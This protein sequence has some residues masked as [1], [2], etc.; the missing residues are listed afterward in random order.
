V[1]VFELK[2]EV[3]ESADPAAAAA[4]ASAAAAADATRGMTKE[5]KEAYEK[6]LKERTEALAKNK[7]LN[8]AFNGAMT[9]KEAK[10]Y[11]EAVAQFTK[12]AGLDANQH[13]VWANL[14]ETYDLM[15][16]AKPPAD[17]AA[18]YAKGFEA[19]DK[20]IAIKGD[21]ASYHN[22]YALML[23]KGKQ[24]DKA[25]A[26]LAKAAEL[27]PPGAGT[28]FYNLGALYTNG[29]QLEPA[30]VAFKKAIDADPTHADAQYQYGIYLMSKAQTKADGTV[31]PVDGTLDAFQKYLELKPT[32][33]FADSAKGMIQMMGATVSTTFANP[34][35]KKNQSKQPAP[36]KK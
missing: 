12:A 31:V 28:Y 23:A 34:D 22:N 36:K 11:D 8:E 24:F 10:N 21:D 2:A 4:A 5:Q 20:A 19:W 25:Q 7:E 35:A 27:N 33:P 18:V 9:A 15:A 16:S 13:V 32:G 14:A 29:G 1:P 30:G 3:A 17:Q 26:E 6:Q